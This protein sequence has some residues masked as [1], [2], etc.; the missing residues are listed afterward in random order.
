[1][2]Q[3]WLERWAENARGARRYLAVFFKWAVVAAAC[4]AVCGA[5]GAAFYHA[6]ALATS[7]RTAHPW[8]LFLLPAAGLAIVGLYHL[9]GVLK[10]EGTNLILASIHTDRKPPLRMAAL[11]FTGTALTHLC[12]GSS[13]REG[14]ALQIG[15]SLGNAV[16][17]R[18]HLDDKDHITL[19]MCGMSAVFCAVFGTPLTA[20]LFSL[21]VVSVG[22]WHYSAL[23]PCLISS[24]AAHQ[25]ATWLGARPEAYLIT[26]TKPLS[27][28]Q[29]WRVMLVAALCAA[30]GILF[31]CALH[32]AAHLY[33][34]FLKNPYARAAAGGV[35]MAAFALAAGRDYTGAGMHVIERAL[36]GECA[37]WAFLL[38][39]AATALTLGAGFKGG[40]IVPA[41]FVG[42]TF[43]CAL[44]NLLH[45]DAGFAAAIGLIAVFCAVVNCPVASIVLSIE[46]FGADNLVL[47][48]LA[49]AVSY[50]LSGPYSLY[51]TQS[52]PYSKLEPRYVDRHTR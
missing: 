24:I 18:L 12:G 51:A 21:E 3:Q 26:V 32:G 31:C 25:V 5:V 8:L 43:G 39:I 44:G 1:M 27:V 45:L 17:A 52:L 35:L 13:G 22:I 10:D 15:G 38:K 23:L 19:T 30:V 2:M 28:A 46:L 49:A 42:A 29:N 47:F 40:E 14:A 16:A 41:F 9:A 4:G 7:L 37:P 6:V 11:I 34:R 33:Q 36:D 50:L 20:A 48:A